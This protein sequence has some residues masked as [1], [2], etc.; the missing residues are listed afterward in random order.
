MEKHA[1]WRRLFPNWRYWV[2][3]PAIVTLVGGGYWT[4]IGVSAISD[5]AVAWQ[6]LAF[7]VGLSLFAWWTVAYSGSKADR[8]VAEVRQEAAQALVEAEG[9]YAVSNE[10]HKTQM[11]ALEQL[12]AQQKEV[13]RVL[14]EV[15]QQQAEPEAAHAPPEKIAAL[16]ISA[17]LAEAV[18][19]EESYMTFTPVIQPKTWFVPQPFS[20]FERLPAPRL[21]LQ[22]AL[23]N[24][25]KNPPTDPSMAL[26]TAK[27]LSSLSQAIPNTLAG[28]SVSE[29][30]SDVSL[31][32]SPPSESSS[33]AHGPPKSSS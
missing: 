7:G 15:R 11:G 17:S 3:P 16:N 25:E 30:K 26:A 14:R 32:I 21:E 18:L 4:W 6:F 8:Q 10:Q 13:I 20:D 2:E 24:L 27:Q 33:G 1:K 28:Y 31:S 23:H 29:T 5:G 22:A 12:S 9:H 19:A